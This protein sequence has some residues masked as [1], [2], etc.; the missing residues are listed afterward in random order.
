MI[1]LQQDEY[2]ERLEQRRL[3]IFISLTMQSQTETMG[4]ILFNGL[5]FLLL[6]IMQLAETKIVLGDSVI[7]VTPVGDF[8]QALDLP[9]M[10]S[11]WL[12]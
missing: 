12:M 9:I 8:P 5:L 3:E 6:I 10:I 11:M 4:A 7:A 1:T 2:K